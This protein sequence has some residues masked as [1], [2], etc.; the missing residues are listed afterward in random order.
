MLHDDCARYGRASNLSGSAKHS[1][2]GRVCLAGSALSARCG[3]NPH[4]YGS[5]TWQRLA[6]TVTVTLLS[7]SMAQAQEKL[8]C[9]HDEATDP[10]KEGWRPSHYE[11]C[12]VIDGIPPTPEVEFGPIFSDQGV[13]AWLVNDPTRSGSVSSNGGYR[14]DIS[15][16]ALKALLTN[17]F[18]LS[19]R[20]KTIR[21]PG[22]IEGA[23]DVELDTGDR[24]WVMA[25]GSQGP[26][27]GSNP[28]VR[29]LTGTG[30]IT[31]PAINVLDPD[32]G[33]HD[34]D[35]VVEPMRGT[36][37]LY[38][39]GVERHV[40]YG[41]V[42]TICRNAPHVFFG[43]G[44]SFDSGEGRYSRV[45]LLELEDSEGSGPFIRGDCNADSQRDISDALCILGWLFLG[46]A[47]PTCVDAADAN[48]SGGFLPDVS[49]AVYLLGW[50]FLGSSPPAP[51]GPACSLDPTPD[52]L[53]CTSYAPCGFF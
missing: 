35:L 48:D 14:C 20:L 47:E 29:L 23:I 16:E 53:D 37:V 39:D 18:R 7:G 31:G 21:D 34:Y 46:T 22:P 49:D 36:S 51:P 26:I 52:E 4:R 25:F 1:G 19:V 15:G 6:L 32:P 50:L 38:V 5:K 28:V 10:E 9:F 3:Y 17:G 30:A 45:V 33:Y 12:G 27:S 42:S 44:H 24:R 8:I 2:P 11:S 43:S 40:G 13:N 41:G